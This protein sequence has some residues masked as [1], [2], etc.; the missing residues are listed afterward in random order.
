MIYTNAAVLASDYKTRNEAIDL[1]NQGVTFLKDKKFDEAISV[2]RKAVVKD[3]GYSL[4]R[5]N[6]SIAVNNK[7]LDLYA[8]GNYEA[9]LNNMESAYFDDPA[10]ETTSQNLSG[11]IRILKLNPN[12]A[13][14]RLGL[15]GKAIW[16]GDFGAAWIELNAALNNVGITIFNPKKLPPDESLPYDKTRD[17][18]Y[19]KYVPLVEAKI[20]NAW[21]PPKRN[22]S[23]SIVVEMTILNDG[24]IRLETPLSD[25]PENNAAKE[26]LKK[27]QPLPKLY[28]TDSDM[29]MRFNFSYNVTDRLGNKK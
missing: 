20:K 2:F 18:F 1:N 28:K 21:T 25:T 15:S 5:K 24:T 26:A 14:D 12:S 19:K 7:G 17:E 4:A 29:R 11:I 22:S 8:K 13:P 10:N 3:P 27:A 16:R 9:C 23:T 6:L